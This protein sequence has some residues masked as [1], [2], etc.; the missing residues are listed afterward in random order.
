[1][2]PEND[3]ADV[4]GCIGKRLVCSFCSVETR[5]TARRWCHTARLFVLF[6]LYFSAVA[7]TA[8]ALHLS[9][10]YV[11]HL[12]RPTKI[13]RKHIPMMTVFDTVLLASSFPSWNGLDVGV[14]W[15]V[16][17]MSVPVFAVGSFLGSFEWRRTTRNI[18]QVEKTVGCNACGW[19][20]C[21]NS[22]W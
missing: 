5:T 1:M 7:V 14:Q 2:P 3:D 15:T 17:D 18:W 21:H 16:T 4:G 11:F 12:F 22:E 19:G 10:V 20:K 6:L 9:R 13:K 8:H